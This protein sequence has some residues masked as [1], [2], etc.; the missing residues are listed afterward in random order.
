MKNYRVVII[1]GGPAGAACAGKLIEE[2]L[3]PLILDKAR[4]PRPKVCAGWITP[5]VFKNLGLLPT[6]YPHDLSEFP[7]LQISLGPVSIPLRGPQYAI[8]RTEFDHW[9]L[10]RSGAE[11]IQHEV[12]DIQPDGTGFLIDGKFSADYLVGAGGTS[13]PVYHQFFKKEHP[14]T[15]SQ[16]VAL[17]EE[18]LTEWKDPTCR[19]WFFRENLPGYAWYVPKK[20]GYVNIG[21]G[22]NA[23]EMK[24]RG[25]A[26]RE[27]WNAFILFLLEKGLVSNREFHPLGYSYYLRGS[28][29]PSRSGNVILAGDSIGLATLDMGEGIG[30][31]IQSGVLAARSI[32]TGVNYSLDA[33]PRFSFLPRG[34]RWLV[35]GR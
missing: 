14:R 19:L 10:E 18:Y 34:L 28:G 20:G 21:L 29:G 27:H 7:S 16:I 30:P 9:L 1:G 17:E 25:K 2:G 5:D 8:R 26:I 23:S 31:A 12:R 24:G 4:F 3:N 13:C 15:G 22:G 35:N 32:L 33:I 11:Y 6:Q